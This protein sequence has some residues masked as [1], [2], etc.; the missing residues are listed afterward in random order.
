MRFWHW[1]TNPKCWRGHDVFVVD[2]V[3]DRVDCACC[4]D[5]GQLFAMYARG[6][7]LVSGMEI[8]HMLPW[9]SAFEVFYRE[10]IHQG[11]AGKTGFTIDRR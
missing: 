10:R 4:N 8:G 9:D 11:Q 3:S 5:C 7:P 1:L 6:I 2:R